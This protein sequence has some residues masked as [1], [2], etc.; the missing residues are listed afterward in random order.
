MNVLN[1]IVKQLE[2]RAS[3]PLYLGLK[4]GLMGVVLFFFYYYRF[5]KDKQYEDK[6]FDLLKTVLSKIV[7]NL[8]F[9]KRISS[10]IPVNDNIIGMVEIGNTFQ[11]LI[12][13]KF[14]AID[15]HD[16]FDDLDK[17]VLQKLNVPATVDFSHETGLIGLC[18]YALHRPIKTESIGLAVNLLAKGFE[19]KVFDI[20]P[21][22]LF[23]SEILQD[24]ELFLLEA[25]KTEEAP[26]QIVVLGRFVKDFKNG[27]SILQ[28]NCHDYTLIQQLREAEI[29]VDKRK[30]RV[31]LATV[32]NEFPDAVLRGLASMSLQK[33]TLPPWWKLF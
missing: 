4:G 13:K 33:P 2:E 31:L 15:F 19:K 18:R 20:N 29:R 27:R 21:V 9:L 30:I 28:S 1:D 26:E 5:T 12:E 22:F 3:R 14:V 25:D 8:D 17:L 11:F 24:I 6:A 23:P 32:A 16:F 10:K 7:A